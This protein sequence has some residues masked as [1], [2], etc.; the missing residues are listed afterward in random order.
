MAYFAAVNDQL[1]IKFYFTQA[2][3]TAILNTTWLVLATTGVSVSQTF[4]ANYFDNLLAPFWRPLMSPD[5]TY[6]GVSVQAQKGLATPPQETSRVNSGVGT[7]VGPSLPRQT[8][9]VMGYRTA[10]AGRS[11][12]SKIFIAF[13]CSQ[14][15]TTGG[16]PTAGWV[17]AIGLLQ[18]SFSSV[19]IVANV[20]NTASLQPVVRHKKTGQVDFISQ[21]APLATKWATQRRRSSFGRP[22][23][24]GF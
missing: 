21:N 6:Y 11:Q 16:V 23:S 8:A 10:L 14:Y 13:P 3:Q 5:A 20:G 7:A 9:Y 1:R 18:P 24:P 17:T 19:Q 12:R 15:N 2:E 4:I 22:N